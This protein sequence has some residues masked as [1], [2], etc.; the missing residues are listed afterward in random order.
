MGG[1]PKGKA[2]RLR[3]DLNQGSFAIY[4]G[5]ALSENSVM[6]DYFISFILFFT[7]LSKHKNPIDLFWKRNP[8]QNNIKLILLFCHLPF[9][10]TTQIFFSTC[11][12]LVLPAHCLEVFG[13]LWCQKKRLL[14]W[15]SHWV[16]NF[17]VLLLYVYSVS[18][19]NLTCRPPCINTWDV[20]IS[21]TLKMV[22]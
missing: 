5:I 15:T 20:I 12:N 9:T 17:Y 1:T 22:H 13:S 16:Q 10:N 14:G 18:G 8:S 11:T 21:F 2:S 19:F 6:F 7:F 4:S 3:Q